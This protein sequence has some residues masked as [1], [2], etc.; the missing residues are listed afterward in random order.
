MALDETERVVYFEGT[1]DGVLERHLYAANLDGGEVRRLT[2]EPGWHQTEISPDYRRFIDSWSSLDHAPSVLLR[3]VQGGPAVSIF[4]QSDLSPSALGL[5]VPELTTVSTRDGMQL[6]AAIY[7]PAEL[8]PGKRYPLVV[9]V[10]GG[11]HAQMVTN[12]WALTVDMRAQYLAQHGFVVLKVDNRG[13]TDRGLA[14]EAAIARNM[15]DI[16]VQDQVD[17]VRAIAQRPYVDGERVGIYG[18]SYGG[19][20]TSMA[21]LRAPDVFKVGVAGAPVTAW[22]GTIPITP[23]AI[24]ARLNPTR[25]ATGAARR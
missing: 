7:E 15:G 20:M 4:E 12:Q 3:D 16:E 25:K 17:A 13:S 23:S 11:P 24:W 1:S 8:E 9:S 6:H 10:Y 5:Q 21:L 18:W 2:S 19:Y 22:D 14:F